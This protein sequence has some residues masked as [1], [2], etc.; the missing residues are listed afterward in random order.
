MAYCKSILQKRDFMSDYLKTHYTEEFFL[1]K[2][3]SNYLCYHDLGRDQ[4]Y[5]SCV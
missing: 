2:I 5:I 1:V 4:F 3:V